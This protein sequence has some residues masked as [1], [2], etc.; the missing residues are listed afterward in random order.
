[1]L[2]YATL[3]PVRDILL[4]M[5]MGE[6]YGRD[7]IWENHLVEELWNTQVELKACLK[8]Q[9][10]NL[11]EIARWEKGSFIN[12]DM[13]PGADVTVACGDVPLLNG[14]MGRKEDKIVIKV[15]GK[16]EKNA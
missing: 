1:M 11:R 13:D 14:T 9:M 6:R 3:E 5:F 16:A 4:Q 12:L 10:I 8:E 15:K 2:P 7:T